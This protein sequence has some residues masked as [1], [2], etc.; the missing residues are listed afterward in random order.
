MGYYT[1]QT[2]AF[3]HKG[4]FWKTRY[5]FTPT[6]YASVDNHF[7]STNAKHPNAEEN[8]ED[9]NFWM[10]ESNISHN[11]FYGK[12]HMSKVTVVS[13]QD[14]SA[15][16]IFK[17][18]SLE[19]NSNN[20][21]GMSSTNINPLGSSQRDLQMGEIKG[22]IQKE[23]NQYSELPKS[24]ANSDSHIDFACTVSEIMTEE[25]TPIVLSGVGQNHLVWDVEA[26]VPNV[27][28]NGGM[29]SLALFRDGSEF[30]YF[31]LD[32]SVFTYTTFNEA[33]QNNA[34][35]VHSYDAANNIIQFGGEASGF[36]DVASISSSISNFGM[37]LYVVSNPSIN[38]DPMRGHY[39]YLDLIN[40]STTPV[41]TYAINVDYEN[42]KLDSAMGRQQNISTTS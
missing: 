5:S 13:N 42:T 27:S 35:H 26:S 4:G 12:R 25:T 17:A 32:G 7:I 24:I 20:W 31:N 15:V 10:H 14:P 28:I 29:G 34:V 23:G 1:G 2:I 21:S 36:V 22:F 3:S 41:E 16:K 18:L 6:C 37:N 19:S 8:V 40:N 38:G 39:L 30:K 11:T 9:V 33:L